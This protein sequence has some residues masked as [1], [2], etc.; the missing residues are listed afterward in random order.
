MVHARTQTSPGGQLKFSFFLVV[1]Q[2]VYKSQDLKQAAH[3]NAMVISVT[4]LP[5]VTVI[6]VHLSK[7]CNLEPGFHTLMMP[8]HPAI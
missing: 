1:V 5:S 6:L 4:M 7:N 3:V 8:M 2:L